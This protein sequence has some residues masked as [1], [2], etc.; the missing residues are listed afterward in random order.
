[1]MKPNYN[2]FRQSDSIQT[3]HGT[4][5]FLHDMGITY[6]THRRPEHFFKKFQGFA[7]STTEL[8]TC[9]ANHVH[10]ILILYTKTD[11]GQVPYRIELDKLRFFDTYTHEGDIQKVIPVKEMQS[12]TKEGW[13]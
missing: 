2:P 6:V 8:E 13:K 7:I 12:R 3:I 4:I 1:M 10:W 11:G 9:H 5:N